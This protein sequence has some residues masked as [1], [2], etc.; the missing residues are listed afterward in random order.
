[1]PQYDRIINRHHPE[2]GPTRPA[3][4]FIWAVLAATFCRIIL[5]TARRFAY[6]FAPALSRGLAVPLTA[7]TSL[8]AL[9]QATGIIGLFFGPL[10]DRLGYRLMMLAGLALLIVGMFGAGLWPVYTMV[11][12]ALLLAGLGKNIFDPSVQAFAGKHV[13]FQR[14]GLVIG[15][16]EFS[17]AAS[18]LVGVP[19]M[20]L[21]IHQVGWRSSFPAL[22]AA[23]LI[24]IL[25]LYRYIRPLRRP[26]KQGTTAESYR[27]A[28]RFMLRKPAALG[29]LGFSFFVSAANDNLFVVY[30]AWL[31]DQFGLG[32]VALG[33]GTGLIGLAELLG[34]VIT[35]AVGDRIGLKRSVIGG[36]A[37][38]M[39]SYT[40]L[41]LAGNSVYL[42]L[43]GLFL[44]FMVFEFTMVCFIS[45]STELLP[46]FRATMMATLMASAGCGRVV[47]ALIGG[48]VWLAAGL[49]G[50]VI[51]SVG[52]TGI[53]LITFYIGVRRW[54]LR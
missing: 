15:I 27:A 32:I 24:G 38:S 48:P 33:M 7:I 40:V 18:T 22:G 17:W 29:A 9:N 13:P 41:L 30:G 49:N 53:A 50:T 28:W 20:G 43:S 37:L 45:L 46:E 10:A 47:G 39:L 21:L 8:I 19:L 4:H 5:N 31:E 42:A 51:V 54:Q 16:M 25:V 6:P 44:I 2:A 3:N 36:L 12:I 14:R 23:G 1:M 35:A 11:L 52:L 34:E 26:V